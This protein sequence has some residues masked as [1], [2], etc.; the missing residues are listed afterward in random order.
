ME[1]KSLTVKEKVSLQKKKSHG[2]I[3]SFTTKEKVSR[4]KKKCHGKRKGLAEKEKVSRQK[5]KPHAERK[6]P[7]PKRNCLAL[8]EYFLQQKFYENSSSLLLQTVSI[9]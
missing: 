4:K 7:H 1:I 5:K 2:K 8:K 6:K 9:K 3:K